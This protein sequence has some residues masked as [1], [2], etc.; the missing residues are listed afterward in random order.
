MKADYD[1]TQFNIG[2]IQCTLPGDNYMFLVFNKDKDGLRKHFQPIYNSASKTPLRGAYHYIGT[3]LGVDTMFGHPEEGECLI[4]AF[5]YK[6]NGNH[7]KKAQTYL[8]LS[9]VR[10]STNGEIRVPI[11]KGEL[12]FKNTHLQERVTFLDYV[13]GGCEIGVHVVIDYTLSNGPPNDQRSL[14]YYGKNMR[15]QYTDAITAVCETLKDYDSDQMFPV[16]GFGGK[17]PN[18]PEDKA[19]FCFALNGDIYNPEV[20]GVEGVRQVYFNSLR[21]VQ[22]FGPT[23]FAPSLDMINGFCDFQE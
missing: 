5:E 14:H 17:V 20:N 3:T 1:K 23:N 12:I 19:S 2:E 10:E 4:Q 9:A 15:N 13:F 18:H 6:Q 21:K 16:Y 8:P 7:K 22:L 11:G